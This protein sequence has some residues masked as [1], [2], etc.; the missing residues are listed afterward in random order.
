ME[1]PTYVDERLLTLPR[2]SFNAGSRTVS[3]IMAVADYARLAGATPARFA[4]DEA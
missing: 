3:V 2:I 1:L 4:G